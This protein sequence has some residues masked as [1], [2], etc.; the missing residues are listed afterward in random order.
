MSNAPDNQKLI[1]KICERVGSLRSERASLEVVWKDCYEYTYPVRSSGLCGNRL[2]ASQA[3]NKVAKLLTSEGTRGARTIASLIVGSMTPSNVL[4]FNIVVEDASKSENA[5]LTTV[6]NELWKTI[7]ASNFDSES[8]ECML[9][10]V[11]SGQFALY[12][13]ESKDS[14][15]LN[16]QQWNLADVF[17]AST[18]K[19]GLIDTVYHAYSMTAEQAVTEFGKDSVSEKLR[20][21]AEKEPNTICNFI[22]M[23]APRTEYIPGSPFNKNLPFLSYHIDVDNKM[24][25][26]E[27]GYHEFPVCFPRWQKQRESVYGVGLVYDALPAIKELNELKRLEKIALDMAAVGMY[28]VVD[29]GILNPETIR[30]SPRGVVAVSDTN[31]IKPLSS[32]ANFNVTFSA[33]DRLANEIRETLMA[34]Q[35]PPVDSGVRTA[36]EFHIRLQY[37]RQLLGPVFGR[38]EAEW[39]QVLITR[40]FG[41]ALRNEWVAVPLSL[42]NRSYTIKYLS[43]LAQS[44]RENEIAS[45]ERFIGQ[46]GSVVQVNP[47]VLDNIDFDETVRLLGEKLSIESGIIRDPETVEQIR[48]ARAKAQQQAQQQ[49]MQQQLAMNQANAQIQKDVNNGA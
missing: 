25:I 33:E 48:K 18:R 28:A 13:D 38:L 29:D 10:N 49:A 42:A 26:R 19:D 8:M 24:L 36:T 3:K 22:H 1:K 39:L 41:I 7:H 11:I 23:I 21:K 31:N 27:S 37:L 17:A 5:A 2:D 45:I 46:V 6:A 30:L 32:G 9:D 34:D 14:S 4:W 16:F 40:C 20:Q 15:G 44:Q 47:E 43:P 35:L 12:I